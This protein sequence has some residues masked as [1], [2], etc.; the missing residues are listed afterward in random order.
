MTFIL[1][2]LIDLSCSAGD[3]LYGVRLVESDCF[4]TAFKMMCL[5]WFTFHQAV[6]LLFSVLLEALGILYSILLDLTFS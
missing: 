4:Q 6:I 2:A 3:V 1:L 5:Y